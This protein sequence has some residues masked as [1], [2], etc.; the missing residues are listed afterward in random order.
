MTTKIAV[1]KEM[2]CISS[3]SAAGESFDDAF[4]KCDALSAANI[5][6]RMQEYRNNQSEATIQAVIYVPLAWGA[7]YLFLFLAGWIRR[8]GFQAGTVQ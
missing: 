1:D 5:P 6:K 7:V 3:H 4:P 8:G 2:S